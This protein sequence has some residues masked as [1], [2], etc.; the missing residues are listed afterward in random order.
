MLFIFSTP[1]FIRNLWQLKTAVFLHWCLILVGP[2]YETYFSKILWQLIP[3]TSRIGG[4]KCH[5]PIFQ[6]LDVYCS[7]SR[8]IL[9]IQIAQVLLCARYQCYI[10]QRHFLQGRRYV[11]IISLSFLDVYDTNITVVLSIMATF[12]YSQN[13]KV[14]APF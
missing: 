8:L 11:P 4:L 1:E 6:P 14:L 5:S 9:T 13:P 10:C 3:L 12:I 2:F 7:Q